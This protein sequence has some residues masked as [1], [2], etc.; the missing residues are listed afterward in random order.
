M[1][2]RYA[3]VGIAQKVSSVVYTLSLWERLLIQLLVHGHYFWVVYG[4]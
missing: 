2:V 4:N 1:N 3:V